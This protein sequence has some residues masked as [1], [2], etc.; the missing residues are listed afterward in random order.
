MIRID[1]ECCQLPQV[2]RDRDGAIPTVCDVCIPHHRGQRLETKLARAESHEATLRKRLT[3]CR[4]SEERARTGMARARE[5][6]AAALASRGA[7]ADRLVEAAET[8]CSRN[9]PAQ[10]LGRD[11]QVAEFARRHRLRQD[12]SWYSD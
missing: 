1:C 3:A 11:P 8:G 4:V 12:S 10:Q 5:G 2:I 6:T 9:C 7:L